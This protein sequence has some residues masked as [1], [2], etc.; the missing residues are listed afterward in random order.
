[1]VKDNIKVACRNAAGVLLNLNSSRLLRFPPDFLMAE[2]SYEFSVNVFKSG[3]SAAAHTVVN[4]ATGS[5]IEDATLELDSQS[6][7]DSNKKVSITCKSTTV[8]SSYQWFVTEAG[9]SLPLA[10][11]NSDPTGQS[12]LL[13]PGVLSPGK[14]YSV[15][16]IVTAINRKPTSLSL[17]ILVNSPPSSGQ[18]LIS[19]SEGIASVTA[20]FMTCDGWVDVDGGIDYQVLIPD[21]SG[22][23]SRYAL[24]MGR[25][26]FLS[27]ISSSNMLNITV[28]IS[29]KFA[30]ETRVDLSVKLSLPPPLPAKDVGKSCDALSQLGKFSEYAQCIDSNVAV[31][32]VTSKNS[33]V[34]AGCC[35]WTSFR[36]TSL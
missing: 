28:V 36:P 7:V 22:S 8:I 32:A 1:M 5:F 3:R 11:S 26:M 23:S 9:A 18:C 20:F 16:A 25:P 27:P 33:P 4:I 24:D 2:T 19:P 14:E 35:L 21:G 10:V 17:T 34:I 13:A 15:K 6:R 30:C 31:Q 12:L 29:D